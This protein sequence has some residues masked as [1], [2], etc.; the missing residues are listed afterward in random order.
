MDKRS[1]LGR[2]ALLLFLVHL[3]SAKLASGN[4]DFSA[5][6]LNVGLSPHPTHRCRYLVCKEDA[7]GK[8]IARQYSCPEYEVYSDSQQ[9]C[10]PEDKVIGNYTCADPKKYC[11]NDIQDCTDLQPIQCVPHAGCT[12]EGIFPSVK[13]CSIYY[14][15]KT[16][17]DVLV[18]V[19]GVCDKG[20]VFDPFYTNETN[21]CK[22]RDRPE[23]CITV[24]CNGALEKKPYYKDSSYYVVCT[25]DKLGYV[26]W[27]GKGVKY[28]P[29][30][31]ECEILSTTTSSTSAT[32]TTTGT[33]K[34]Q[35]L[36]L[37]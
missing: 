30:K 33:T 10:V 2:I 1:G 26:F 3:G 32:V 8:L 35:N 16:Q 7:Y 15:C 12:S 4:E 23:Y 37:D 11:D 29:I 24:P 31:K 28:D 17:G 27:C 36:E 6:C 22:H 13:N 9:S 14:V 25:P 18:D 5:G 19:V 34:I 20:Y 21:P